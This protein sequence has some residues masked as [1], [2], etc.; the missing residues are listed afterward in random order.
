MPDDIELIG[1]E[2]DTST[3]PWASTYHEP[4]EAERERFVDRARKLIAGTDYRAAWHDAHKAYLKVQA[5]NGSEALCDLLGKLIAERVLLA[6][7]EMQLASW[8]MPHVRAA[9]SKAHAPAP[10]GDAS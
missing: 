10:T 5:E 9:L 6:I 2:A 4:M 3:C 1:G 7:A 8:D